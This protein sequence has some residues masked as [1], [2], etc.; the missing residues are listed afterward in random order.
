MPRVGKEALSQ[1]IRTECFRLLR[2]NLSPDVQA[3]R[4]ERTAAGMPPVQPPRPGL[5][6]LAQAGE[7]WQAEKVADLSDTFG[8]S[9]V[10]GDR[11]TTQAGNE[12]FREIE[13]VSVLPAAPLGCFIVEAQFEVGAAFEG[14]LGIA[15]YR[16][17]Y[18]LSYARLRPDLIE[19]LPAATADLNRYVTPA[20][21]VLWLG[22]DD[23]RV[24]LRV[25][26]IKLTAEPS[27]SYFAEVTYYSM[28]L[29]GW[30]LDRG[31]ANRFVVVP[32]AAIWPGSHDASCLVRTCR[33]IEDQGGTATYD[34]MWNAMRE[35]LEPVPFEVFVGRVKHFFITD[36]PRAFGSP[37]QHLPWHVDNRCKGCDY[38]G[39]PWIDRNGQPTAH[40][41]H[42]MPTAEQT[43]HLS[44]VAFISR[45]ASTAL[46]DQGITDVPTLA[47]LQ[48]NSPVFNAHYSL[49]ATRN[50]VSGRAASLQ[51]QQSAIPPQAGTSGVMPKYADLHIY[52]TV[53]FDLGS[54]ITFALGVKGFWIEP[55]PFGYVGQRTTQ[56]YGPHTHVVDQ[57]DLPVERRELMAFLNEINTILTD[58][59]NRNAGTTVQ[60][61]IWD[62]VQ[63]KHLTRIIGRHLQA[64]L[65]DQS[66]QHLAALRRNL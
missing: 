23:P 26:D 42:C 52:I 32:N 14:A 28:A 50:V 1:F 27:P 29:A 10:I 61:Y 22:D 24:K 47:Q 15:T 59:R 54:A 17:A 62:S 41:L 13:L 4:H 56:A 51:A 37:W 64:I 25:I 44:R 21:A 65:A 63:Y 39:Y 7:E 3:F 43:G 16:Q 36:L 5:E 11:Y 9:I 45:G 6:Y 40:A 55:R 58:A 48:P 60:F 18:D 66:I 34:Q 53:D 38:L 57:K 19:V 12:R 20:G 46:N 2:L 8:A 31:L 30:L 35:D 49:R 33:E